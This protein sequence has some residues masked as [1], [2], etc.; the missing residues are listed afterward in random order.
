MVQRERKKVMTKTYIQQCALS[1]FQERGYDKTTVEQIADAAG[2]S[3]RTFFRYFP[4]KEDVVLH[5]EYD[6]K[7]VEAFEAQPLDLGP[8]EALRN[9]IQE[10]FAG[11]SDFEL[12]AERER[13]RLISSVPELRAQLFNKLTQVMSWLAQALA[14]RLGRD[15]DD[16]TIH[17]YIGAILGTIRAAEL[18]SAE[19]SDRNYLELVDDALSF[20]QT[21]L[22]M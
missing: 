22:L 10:V 12:S 3:R 14:K 5:D 21:R 20:L 7:I 13:S 16:F 18:Y 15:P 11:L 4:T 2:V 9:A 17:M 8:I 19:K 6:P 1:L